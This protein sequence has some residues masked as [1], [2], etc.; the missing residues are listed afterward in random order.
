MRRLSIRTFRFHYFV[1]LLMTLYI[2]QFLVQNVAGSAC[3]SMMMQPYAVVSSSPILL[4]EGIT[5][6]STIYMNSTSAKV[7][8]TAPVWLGNW[9]KRVKLTIDH[10]DIDEN[11]SN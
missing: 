11:L 3:F 10:N 6:T 7:S 4:E 2:M 9:S 8:V 1:R 5:G